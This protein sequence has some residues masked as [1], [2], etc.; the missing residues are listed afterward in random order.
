L[1]KSAFGLPPEFG[2][3]HDLTTLPRD[4]RV[5]V[6]RIGRR[7]RDFYVEAEEAGDVSFSEVSVLSRLIRS[8]PAAPGLLA[9]SEHVTPQAVGSVL[10]ALQR[11]GLIDRSPDPADGRRVIVGITARG[12]QAFDQRSDVVTRRLAAALA[13]TLTPAELRRLAGV[14]PLLERIADEL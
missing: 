9:D 5:V 1:I 4:L 14:L 6:G 13:I 3:H 7:L 11:R 2:Q 8:G 10:S 12:R